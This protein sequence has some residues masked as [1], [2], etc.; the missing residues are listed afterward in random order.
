MPSFQATQSQRSGRIGQWQ[1]AQTTITSPILF[2]VVCFITGSTA[3]GGGLWKYILQADVENSILRRN[4]PVM[5]QVLHFLDFKGISPYLL[6]S[7]LNQGIRAKYNTEISPSLTY[8]API[9]L[10]SGGFQL[11]WN[12]TLDLSRFGFPSEIHPETILDLQHRF[13]GDIIATLDYPLP[14]GLASDEVDE[15]ILKSQNNALDALTF[16]HQRTAQQRPFLHIAVHG[17]DGQEAGRYVKDL[18]VRIMAAGLE[19]YPFGLAVGSLV[20]LRGSGKY[21][22]I[23][24]I[25]SNVK[26]SIPEQFQDR[27]PL[28]VFGIT[29]NLIP[30]LVA[31]GV[32]SF[33]SSNYV[34]KARNLRYIDPASYDVKQ[35]MEMDEIHCTCRICRT[36][37][38][39]EVKA[40]LASR[41]RN[42]PL[43]NG[44][45]KSKYYGDI[46][47][48]NLEVDFAI[49]TKVHQALSASALPQLLVEH[50]R[51]YPAL[52][53]AAAQL[54]KHVPTFNSLYHTKSV[55][56]VGPAQQLHLWHPISLKHI[57]EDF[58]INHNGYSPPRGKNILLIIPCS[59]GKPYSISRS[60]RLIHE[61]LTKHFQDLTLRIHKVTLSGLYG[62]VPEEFENEPMI[63][64]YDFRLDSVNVK[65]IDLVAQRLIVYL[66]KHAGSY[67]LMLGYA[68]SKAYRTAMLMAAKAIPAFTV[69][70]ATLRAQT[71][72]EFFRAT[73]IE[74][75]LAALAPALTLESHAVSD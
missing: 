31:L 70:P 39:P 5:S 41:I 25:V 3:R 24:D 14:P 6:Q 48:H 66:Q 10:D 59:G 61:R 42:R 22:T 2:P 21:D 28:H 40:G 7:W 15:R 64:S 12:N 13:D 23:I 73:N 74:A 30:L 75:L 36:L 9:F 62:P 50:V 65:Q 45:F 26:R 1:V 35:I 27:I 19:T 38:L 34:Q 18:F 20:P 56:S 68:T 46:A 33:D 51:R 55:P 54:A 49:I 69:L 63:L 47:L 44:L 29:G 16:L 17:R 60:H 57:P 8:S 4:L 67:D 52:A 72:P 71:L 58:D 53:P 32:D 11:L 37:R 43:E